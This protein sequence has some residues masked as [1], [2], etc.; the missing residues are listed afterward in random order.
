M[1][2]QVSAVPVVKK[3]TETIILSPFK[4][5]VLVGKD[6]G[7]EE[8]D[9]IL[10]WGH[11]LNNNTVCTIVSD[12]P[13]YFYFEFPER[14]EEMGR[15]DWTK[16]MAKKV[17]LKL[18]NALRANSEALLPY[19]NGDFCHRF[20][21]YYYQSV[22]RPM[23][24]LSFK[25]YE[26]MKHARNILDVTTKSKGLFYEQGWD[27]LKGRVLLMEIDP[28]RKLL[29][30]RNI[31]HCGWIECQAK[32]VTNKTYK[33]S[34]LEN[35]YWVKYKSIHSIESNVIPRPLWCSYDIETYS[36]N[37]KAFPRHWNSQDVIYLITLVFYRDGDTSDKWKT[38][39]VLNGD[40]IIED[41]EV[42]DMTSV[43]LVKNEHALIKQFCKLVQQQDPDFLTGYHTLGFDNK[44]ID[45]RLKL[46]GKDEWPIL[47]RLRNRTGQ[48]KYSNWSSS[49]YRDKEMYIP[50]TPG[51]CSLDF[52]E[53]TT[54]EYKWSTYSLANAAKNILEDEP[55]KRKKDFP[56][57]Q[58]FITFKAMREHLKAA[59]LGVKGNKKHH[60]EFTEHNLL[61]EDRPIVE[62]MRSRNNSTSST[63]A[64]PLPNPL[65]LPRDSSVGAAYN[66]E[67]KAGI[68]FG[69]RAKEL[70]DMGHLVVYGVYDSLLIGYMSNK[71][72][73]WIGIREMCNCVGVQPQ[74]LLTRGQQA[75]V[76]S[77]LFDAAYRNEVI[78]D[79]RTDFKPI[80][81][82]GGSVQTPKPG[83]SYAAFTL[84]FC[85]LYPNI[86]IGNNLCYTT[87]IHPNEHR[88]YRRLNKISNRVKVADR[89]PDV[90]NDD[91]DI[92]PTKKRKEDIKYEERTFKFV[93][94]EVKTG[95]LC[96][97]LKQLLDSRNKIKGAMS[98][99]KAL[100]DKTLWIVANCQQN[101]MKV[102]ANS[103]YGFTGA[104]N[105]SRSI[106]EITA[107]VTFYGRQYINKSIDWTVENYGF[108]K[109][110]GDT[111]S[112]MMTMGDTPV[113]LRHE[114]AAKIAIE[115]CNALRMPDTLRFELEGVYDMFCVKAKN[116]AKRERISGTD[117]FVM[118]AEG[119]PLL[120]IK[121]MAPARRDV[122]KWV[123]K[124]MIEIINYI[125]DG[126]G[127]YECV[128]YL[129]RHVV[130]LFND[131]VSLYD[132]VST[133]GLSGSYS[134]D[135]ASMKVFSEEMAKQGLTMNAG[136]RHEYIIVDK[137]GAKNVGRRMILLSLYE[138]QDEEDRY[139]LDYH[140]YYS[141]LEKKVDNILSAE[142]A[143]YNDTLDQVFLK[144][145]GRTV[146]AATPAKFLK[147]ILKLEMS[148]NQYLRHVKKR[149]YDVG[150]RADRPANAVEIH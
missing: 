128:M 142:Y 113:E 38:Y 87:M 2:A 9:Q 21:L 69:S 146:T 124:A 143:K 97:I 85:S 55:D 106:Q 67:S 26:A 27:S 105:G 42:R 30:D 72:N 50:Y 125:M 37:H 34:Y 149:C 5:E 79:T 133:R 33:L 75:R 114:L 144:V 78:L 62:A 140:H 8:W 70:V 14:Y 131:K 15:D 19:R 10:I 76:L 103:V 40:C 64:D 117:K 52:Y 110:Y 92:S 58:Q 107:M 3:S 54:R 43:I 18:Q 104:V 137:P 89:D 132:L 148:T 39:A 57:E 88:K 145:R 84:D 13:I 41:T 127:F 134:L 71:I 94:K 65:P 31:K 112:Y 59:K 12:F 51:R 4:W 35:E 24:K 63:E 147:K 116:Y 1:S 98:K 25:N 66:G 22:P 150:K 11:D 73:W 86:M 46:K 136:E 108:E 23:L 29:T 141:L 138:S 99:L 83:F 100:E 77:M 93:A 44:Y 90:D 130:M 32:K 118:A 81:L 20:T 139:P 96:G 122:C 16:D 60:V 82:E 56:A 74:D 126:Y 68:L 48:I 109:I 6:S 28:I 47:G 119:R 7:D 61:L 135:N 101:A 91:I 49:A 102:S 17:H 120:L 80:Y 53:H 111:D 123:Q 115:V 36:H 129:V 121:G 45:A 95:I